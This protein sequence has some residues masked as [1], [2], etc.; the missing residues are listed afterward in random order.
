MDNL[1]TQKILNANN[2]FSDYFIDGKAFYLHTFNTLPNIN[3]MNS[4]N[5]EKVLNALK[6]NFPSEIK[7]IYQRRWYKRKK[8]R[9]EFDKT[10]VVFTD[11]IV[12]D[13]SEK[14]LY[15][16]HDSLHGE[17]FDKIFSLVVKFKKQERKEPLEI[18]LI[19]RY[20]SGLDLK[21]MEIKRTKLDLD[22]FYEDDFK[23]TD[24][25]IQQRLKKKNDK[26]IV[27]LH[28]L[29]GTG[30]TTYLRYLVGKIK[31]RVLFLSPSVA[32]NLM[33]PD[34]IELLADNPNTI[35]VI[36]DAENIIMDRKFNSSSSVSN[37]LNISDG[38]LADFLN[39]QL[40][41]TFNSALTMIDSALLRK[42]RLIARYEFG[43]LSIAKAQRLSNHFGFETVITEPMS[44]AEV[45]NP[46]EKN[47]PVQR[48]EVIGFR[49]NEALVN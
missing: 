33:N 7:N 37:L 47:E 36:E 24:A 49:R 39:V 16:L 11:N 43:K 17:T 15:I 32:G 3:F 4:V 23:E 28:G 44:I 48:P 6:E 45:A 12:L 34:F 41:C 25:I 42:G 38:L 22:L 26:G 20:N 8:K 18:N 27:L 21:P 46:H 9:F 19:V 13:I 29:P 40:I 5:G 31:K 1:Y 14:Y 2:V 10:L 30:K 35:L